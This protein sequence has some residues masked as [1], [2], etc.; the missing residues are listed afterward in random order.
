MLFIIQLKYIFFSE[1]IVK[2]L[3]LPALRIEVSKAT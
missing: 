2:K 1:L 3:N